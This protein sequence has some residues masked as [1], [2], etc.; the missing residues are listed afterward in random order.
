M[1][2]TV[3]VFGHE[4]GKLEGDGNSQQAHRY[5]RIIATDTLWIKSQHENLRNS[6]AF[7]L[8]LDIRARIIITAGFHTGRT[9]VASFFDKK[10]LNDAGLVVDDITEVDVDGRKR[11]WMGAEYIESLSERERWHVLAVLKRRVP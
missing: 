10:F 9:I 5:T 2:A 7:F 11:H 4:W 8:D 3:K 1:Q 6:M